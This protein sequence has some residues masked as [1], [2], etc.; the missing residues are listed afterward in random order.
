MSVAVNAYPFFFESAFFTPPCPEHAPRPP[1]LVV[2]S[3]H[4]TSLVANFAAVLLSVF[5]LFSAAFVSAFAG[6]SGAFV[7][8]FAFFSAAFVSVLAVFSAAFVLALPACVA[9]GAPF[10]LTPPWFEHA[11][12]PVAFEVVPSLQIVFPC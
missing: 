1:L 11:P 9:A 7:T 6:F 12:R 3:V 5:A 2:P 4:V 10:V 8:A